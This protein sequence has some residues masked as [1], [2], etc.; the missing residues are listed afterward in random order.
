[1]EGNTE[2][3]VAGAQSRKEEKETA[4]AR[5]SEMRMSVHETSQNPV[6][7]PELG[8]Q[9]QEPLPPTTNSAANKLNKLK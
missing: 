3:K 8:T 6:P 7:Y 9:N 1:L 4:D 2:R 5:E